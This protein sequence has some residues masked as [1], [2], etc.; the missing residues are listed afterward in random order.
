[1]TI[2][3]PPV[4]SF[5]RKRD[6]EG[7]DAKANGEAGPEGK[8]RDRRA[9]SKDFV[10]PMPCKARATSMDSRFRGNDERVG[11]PSSPSA[12]MTGKKQ[13]FQ[14]FIGK[15][16]KRLLLVSGLL[17]LLAACI[18]TGAGI[19]KNS[20]RILLVGNSIIYTNNLP[21]VFTQIVRVQPYRD[22]YHVDIFARG[23]A[24]LTEWAR[25]PRLLDA[26]ASSRYDIVVL[27]EKGG[28]DLCVLDPQDR[29]K[30]DCQTLIDSHI[31]LASLARK[32]GARVLYLGTY[33]SMP[34]ISKELVRAERELST[35]MNAEY[36]EIS[37][38][39]Q[40]LRQSQPQFPWLY[41]DNGHPGIA[42]TA[43]M[44]VALYETLSGHAGRPFDLCLG[45]ELYTP[46]WRHAGVA[47]DTET[48]ADA[49]P[50]RCLLER[51]QMDAII[52]SR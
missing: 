18:G 6:C 45:A 9:S 4:S 47:A 25:E 5:P 52:K 22:E 13:F 24:T 50:S 41:A 37:E 2:E 3:A 16:A 49:Q 36:V 40:S 17:G 31:R 11:F 23:G 14:I 34:Q 21:A 1:M 7:M 28:D 19:V 27:Q 12:R 20:Q 35:M 33:Q 38:R 29:K 42:T 44:G 26:L 51:A 43:L 8:R 39:W 10:F 32:Y 46:K 15:F 48:V 30:D